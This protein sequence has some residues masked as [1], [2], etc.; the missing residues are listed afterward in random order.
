MDLESS[1]EHLVML[2]VMMYVL[3]DSL[4]INK[5]CK[6]YLLNILLLVAIMVM[7]KKNFQASVYFMFAFVIMHAFSTPS[8][9]SPRKIEEGFAP[10]DDSASSSSSYPMAYTVD[11]K[12]SSDDVPPESPS[13]Y[14]LD[15]TAMATPSLNPSLETSVE[16]S[17]E[18][19]NGEPSAYEADY[20]M[21]EEF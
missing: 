20:M 14:M 17:V 21:F 18:P 8:S 10:I 3:K 6:S 5:L 13:A 11:H 1:A 7:S 2:P 15:P 9:C 16:P 19:V 4:N 12:G